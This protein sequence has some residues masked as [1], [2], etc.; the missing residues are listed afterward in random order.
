MS[1]AVSK[2]REELGFLQALLE[3]LEKGQPNDIMAQKL[4]RR[5]AILDSGLGEDEIDAVLAASPDSPANTGAQQPNSL[6]HWRDV[7]SHTS[8]NQVDQLPPF[9]RHGQPDKEEE[10]ANSV[11]V[12][13]NLAWG[14]HYGG[15]YPHRGCV[16]YI[17]R[18]QSELDSINADPG[19][20]RGLYTAS[21]RDCGIGLT[22]NE[23]RK[24]VQFHIEYITWHH[25]AVHS[26]T[27]MA[28]CEIFWK[29]GRHEHPLWVALYLSVLS[30]SL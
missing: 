23:A 2:H 13:E 1:H 3:D 8:R 9:G 14:R 6:G 16:C 10:M 25:N 20:M 24:L 30:V 7:P 22:D 28:Q 19:R 17:H 11:A 27:F 5:I 15:C 4:R 12:L 29:T 18:S 26:L 21:L